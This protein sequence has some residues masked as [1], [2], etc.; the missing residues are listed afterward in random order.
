M[1]ESQSEARM[2]LARV[3]LLRRPCCLDRGGESWII[4]GRFLFS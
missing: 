4:R 2:G 3:I 1:A